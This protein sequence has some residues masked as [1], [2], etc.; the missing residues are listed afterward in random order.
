MCEKLGDYGENIPEL[1]SS[2]RGP[3]F[4]YLHRIL[5]YNLYI[6][7]L[8]ILRTSLYVAYR[9]KDSKN[10]E[11]NDETFLPKEKLCKDFSCKVEKKTKKNGKC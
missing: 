1:D 3:K 10:N 8:F 2:N 5:I 11:I 7:I 9:A 6:S 4:I